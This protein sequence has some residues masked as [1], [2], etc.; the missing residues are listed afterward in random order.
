MNATTLQKALEERVLLCDGAM[1]TELQK[2]D[3]EPGG[4]G[5]Y[6][7]LERPE[8]VL[9]IHR[10]YVEAGA[11]CISTNT[12]GAS[13]LMLSRH[14]HG[15]A[16]EAIASAGVR[17][18][19]EALGARRGYVL[20]D[21]GPL[22]GLLEPYGEIS[23]ARA[24]DAFSEQ[25]GALVA[26]HVDAVLIETQTALEEIGVAIAAARAVGAPLIIGSIA[27][28]VTHAGDDLRTM[29]GVAPEDA[30]RYLCD[31]GVDVLGLNCGSGV[32]ARWAALAVRR[33]RAVSGLPTLAQPNAG[34]PVLENLEAVY[35]QDPESM[36]S[37]IDILLE[38]GASMVGGCCGTTPR[39]TH[40]FRKLVDRH[41]RSRS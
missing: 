5:E 29:M 24:H 35:K 9:A 28:D 39:H 25:I 19:R 23:E 15:N 18:A 38:A 12:F 4:C 17:L 7:N 22:G 37:G 11:D 16:V 6:L 13:R 31:A 1:G 2:Y 40:L 27:Y 41:N 21:V 20:G 10:A 30:A 8:T 32:D 14:G 26:A 36:A 3:L 33:Y 34:Q